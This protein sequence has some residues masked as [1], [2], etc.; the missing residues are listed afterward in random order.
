MQK[1]MIVSTAS[2]F[3]RAEIIGWM[4]ENGDALME[5]VRNRKRY[6]RLDI[7]VGFI[8]GWKHNH[9]PTVLHAIGD[10]WKLLAPPAKIKH[11]NGG[12]DY[13]E[14]WLVRD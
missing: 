9:Y 8:G 13:Y 11:P 3:L 6:D 7:P 4:H 10:S 14:W 12:E 2:P 1:I 5:A